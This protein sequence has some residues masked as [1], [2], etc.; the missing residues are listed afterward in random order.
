MLFTHVYRLHEQPWGFICSE[1]HNTRFMRYLKKSWKV[2]QKM[3]NASANFNS[4][5]MMPQKRT[6]MATLRWEYSSHFHPIFIKTSLSKYDMAI[7]LDPRSNAAY[8]NRSAVRYKLGHFHEALRDAQHSI[9]I[10][11]KWHKVWMFF[12]FVLQMSVPQYAWNRSSAIQFYMTFFRFQK[13]L[14]FM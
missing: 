2:H 10:E 13:R 3:T 9:E 12:L 11:P 6:K 8:A 4:F 1:A 14:N 7:R 5:S